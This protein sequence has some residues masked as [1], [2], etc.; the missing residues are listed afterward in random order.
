MRAIFT[1]LLKDKLA[2]EDFSNQIDNE[3][4]RDLKNMLEK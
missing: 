2:K 3:L 1:Y 4:Q